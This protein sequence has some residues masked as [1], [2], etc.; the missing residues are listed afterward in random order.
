VESANAAADMTELLRQYDVGCLVIPRLRH[1]K[2][3]VFYAAGNLVTALLN[4]TW[5]VERIPR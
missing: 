1:S 3:T 2:G 4:E 5:I